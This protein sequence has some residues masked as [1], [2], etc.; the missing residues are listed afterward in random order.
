MKRQRKYN[1]TFEILKTG[2]TRTVMVTT[3]DSLS[4]ARIVY[5]NFGGKKIKVTSAKVVKENE[6]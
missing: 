4:A 5:T 6:V 2:C 1:V 3:T